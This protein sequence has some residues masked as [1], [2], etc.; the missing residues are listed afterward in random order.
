MNRRC[1]LPNFMERRARP[2]DLSSN[3]SSPRGRW[4][5]FS[6]LAMFKPE[7][8]HPPRSVAMTAVGDTVDWSRIDLEIGHT[9]P[10]LG[11]GIKFFMYRLI[12]CMRHLARHAI[13]QSRQPLAFKL[14]ILTVPIVLKRNTFDALSVPRNKSFACSLALVE[15]KYMLWSRQ[16]ETRLLS[17]VFLRP[18]QI[19]HRWTPRAV[20]PSTWYHSNLSSYQSRSFLSA[21][22]PSGLCFWLKPSA[23]A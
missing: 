15:H 19:H 16:I 4:E 17:L 11:I 14:A 10:A 8:H 5:R 20:A 13:H 3:S 18:F 23:M 12:T 22:L 2:E 9:S 7:W 21:C 6:M 1:G